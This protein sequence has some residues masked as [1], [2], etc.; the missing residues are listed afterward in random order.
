MRNSLLFVC[1]LMLGVSTASGAGYYQKGMKAYKNLCMSCHGSPEYGAE[2]LTQ[3]EWD[4]W[5]M[6]KG[7]KL[8]QVHQS[9]KEAS[10]VLNDSYAQKRLKQVHKF[11]LGAAKDSGHVGGCDGNRCG[12]QSGKYMMKKE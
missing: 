12:V 5:F 4:D 8:I 11:L 3:A 10:E 1:M 6:F 7:K 9:N 2:Q